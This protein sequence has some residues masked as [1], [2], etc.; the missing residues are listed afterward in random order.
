M[1]KL[2]FSK[3]IIMILLQT[4]W[5]VM[6]FGIVIWSFH[7]GWKLNRYNYEYVMIVPDP[8]EATRL[9]DAGRRVIVGYR[10]LCD[11]SDW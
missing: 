11:R 6:Q 1:N 3:H 5:F 9:H 4:C 7:I 10:S 8:A 2:R